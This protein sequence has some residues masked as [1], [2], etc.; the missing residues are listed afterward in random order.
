MGSLQRH[1]I[2]Q[3]TS[4]QAYKRL[5]LKRLVFSL[6]V[7]VS[8]VAFTGC[9]PATTARHLEFFFS[10][11]VWG[12]SP[13]NEAQKKQLFVAA[14]KTRDSERIS[15]DVPFEIS[16]ASVTVKRFSALYEVDANIGL[17]KVKSGYLLELA[18]SPTPPERVTLTNTLTG[19]SWTIKL[20]ARDN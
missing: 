5:H 4:H 15:Q 7:F 20:N 13:F 1:S 14:L 8:L 18:L 2:H 10:E 6:F 11:D 12:G 9:V 19:V 3:D 17:P 16:D